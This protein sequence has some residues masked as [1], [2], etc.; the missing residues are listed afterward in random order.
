MKYG[1]LDDNVIIDN[2]G[3]DLEILIESTIDKIQFKDLYSILTNEGRKAIKVEINKQ[4]LI[5]TLDSYNK[6]LDLY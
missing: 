1:K 4:G 2:L 3:N 5:N 6:E